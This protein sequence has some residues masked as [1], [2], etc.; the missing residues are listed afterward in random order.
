MRSGV[1]RTVSSILVCLAA[2]VSFAA[3]DALVQRVEDAIHAAEP[4][5]ICIH[6]VWNGP[7]PDV[8]SEKRLVTSVWEHTAKDGTRERINLDISQV[9][10][11]DDASLSLNP[12][13]E[14]KVAPGWTVKP[15]HIGDEG[16]LVTYKGGSRFEIHFFK[17]KTIVRVKSDSIELT[18]KFAKYTEEQISSE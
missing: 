10:S 13:R 5:W 16:Y 12:V 18:E 15:Y 14:E 17:D 6:A 8:A 2:A 1:L 7:P 11:R 4:G 3:N 9:A